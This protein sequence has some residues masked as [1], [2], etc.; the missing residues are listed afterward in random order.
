[1]PEKNTLMG[2]GHG[3][4]SVPLPFIPWGPGGPSPSLSLDPVYKTGKI[5]PI[6]LSSWGVC[7]IPLKELSLKGPEITNM[8]DGKFSQPWHH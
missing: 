8:L 5:I 7:E 3:E 2:P 4:N 1:M 6:C